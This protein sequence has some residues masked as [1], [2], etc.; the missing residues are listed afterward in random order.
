MRVFWRNG[1]KNVFRWVLFRLRLGSHPDQ[2][3]VQIMVYCVV[4]CV[5]VLLATSCTT[6]DVADSSISFSADSS[7]SSD[8][9]LV[10]S[11]QASTEGLV[12]SVSSSSTPIEEP[13]PTTSTKENYASDGSV[14]ESGLLSAEVRE[15]LMEA[16]ATDLSQPKDAIRLESVTAQTWPNGCLGL[17][18]QDELCTM[19]LVEGWQ[20][21]VSTGDSLAIYRSNENGTA[22]RRAH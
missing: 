4:L 12:P 1:N 16:I 14:S 5:V 20:I 9:A 22:V 10:P 2:K 3:P 19:A 21:E 11:E 8:T 15:R 17:A 18:T 7:V 6:A 13:G